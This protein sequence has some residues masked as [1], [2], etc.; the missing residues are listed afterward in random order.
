L[1]RFWEDHWWLILLLAV[2]AVPIVQAIFAP[3]GR[4]LQYRE[5][6]AAIDTLK[7]YATQGR[8]PPP[9][10]IDALAPRGWR[11]RARNAQAAQ[12]AGAGFGAAV[13]AAG[14]AVGR[15]GAAVDPDRWYG[16]WRRGEPV[17]RWN[18]AIFAG[19]ITAG[20]AYAYHV[21]PHND[22]FLVVAVIAG[23]MTVAAVASALIATFWRID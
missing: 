15:A 16:R 13:G 7:V 8:E 3:W 14:A 6:R 1:D 10:V 22:V 2:L 21:Q 20:F 9:E 12:A 17:R 5:R 18:G 4:Y 23:A 19:A 11:R